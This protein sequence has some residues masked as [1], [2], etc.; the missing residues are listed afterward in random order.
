M[1]PRLLFLNN[2]WNTRLTG[3]LEVGSEADPSAPEVYY[4]GYRR[5]EFILIVCH[6]VQRNSALLVSTGLATFRVVC[7]RLVYLGYVEVSRTRGGTNSHH[8]PAPVFSGQGTGFDVRRV[9]EGGCWDTGFE[10][11]QSPVCGGLATNL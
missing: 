3:M 7:S 9:I 5:F 8:H 4:D 2:E 6:F 11:E 10:S 1:A